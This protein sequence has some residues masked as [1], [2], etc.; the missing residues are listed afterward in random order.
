MPCPRQRGIE[1]AKARRRLGLIPPGADRQGVADGA[2]GQVTPG[3]SRHRPDVLGQPRRLLDRHEPQVEV[4]LLLEPVEPLA[5]RL[6]EEDAVGRV[7]PLRPAR[8][9]SEVGVIDFL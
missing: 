1:P 6:R 2:G 8:A 3:R 4:R 5:H 9:E 7:L